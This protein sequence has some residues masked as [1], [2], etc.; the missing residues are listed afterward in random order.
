MCGGNRQADAYHEAAHA[1]FGVIFNF[2][3]DFATVVPF[4]SKGGEQFV[5]TCN[6]K[7]SSELGPDGYLAGGRLAQWLLV[8]LAGC[9]AEWHWGS[10]AYGSMPVSDSRQVN[11]LLSQL[12]ESLREIVIEKSVKQI[13]AMIADPSTWRAI[14]RIGEMLLSRDRID[15]DEIEREVLAIK[16]A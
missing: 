9:V 7:A 13:E 3:I 8:Q 5:G 14:T 1:V 10:L 16:S 11:H 2:P 12:P 4:I 6:F 15:G